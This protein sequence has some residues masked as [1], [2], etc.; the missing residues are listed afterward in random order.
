MSGVRSELINRK[1]GQGFI[2][3]FYFVDLRQFFTFF[4]YLKRSLD[5]Y[6]F[7]GYCNERPEHIYTIIRVGERPRT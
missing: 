3:A 7:N 2:A 6:R 1:V 5:R 4:I